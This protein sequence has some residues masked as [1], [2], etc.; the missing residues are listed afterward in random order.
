MRVSSLVVPKLAR[1]LRRNFP[2]SLNDS[3]ILLR[4]EINVVQS[5]LLKWLDG[6]HIHPGIIGEFDDSALMKVFGQAG[7]GIFVARPQSPAKSPDTKACRSL[8]RRKP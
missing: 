4:S 7:A 8:N 1:K 5:R 3:L 6:L 2:Q